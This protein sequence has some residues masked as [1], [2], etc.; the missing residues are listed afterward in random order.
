M[1][2]HVSVISTSTLLV[3]I[4]AVPKDS[5]GATWRFSG[6]WQDI[7][8]RLAFFPIEGVELFEIDEV[9]RTDKTPIAFDLKGTSAQLSA[10]G[11]IAVEKV[12]SG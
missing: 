4:T 5:G 6:P 7:R 9:V 1:V 11:F 3:T 10:A 8:D 12:E 2:F